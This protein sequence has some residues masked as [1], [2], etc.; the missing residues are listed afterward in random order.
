MNL[1]DPKM[2]IGSTSDVMRCIH[3]GLLCVQESITSRPTMNTVVLMLTSSSLS[4][5]MPSKPAFYIHT[6]A[7]PNSSQS[8]STSDQSRS[9]SV[10]FSTNEATISEL[11]PR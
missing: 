5:P 9:S 10:L 11:L 4:L 3:I 1:I 7:M 8:T 2:N 6:T